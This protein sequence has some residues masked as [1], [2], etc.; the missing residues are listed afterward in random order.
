MTGPYEM[1]RQAASAAQHIYDS[2]PA[3]GAWT[4]GCHRLM[5]DACTAAGVQLGA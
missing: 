5:E 4:G 1:E 2:P 3:T